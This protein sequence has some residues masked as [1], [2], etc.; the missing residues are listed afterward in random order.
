MDLRLLFQVSWL[1]KALC[2]AAALSFLC[3][4]MSL[5]A[6]TKPGDP[7]DGIMPMIDATR[8]PDLPSPDP[9][10]LVDYLRDA[11]DTR[12]TQAELM[13]ILSHINDADL[14][15]EVQPHHDAIA[16]FC[17]RPLMV[18]DLFKNLGAAAQH[19]LIDLTAAALSEEE[20]ANIGAQIH[21]R[22]VA[23]TPI[24]ADLATVTYLNALLDRIRPQISRTNLPWQV[25]VIDDPNQMNAISTAGGYIYF[26]TGL[27]N[28]ITNEA[29]LV[30][31][32]AHE[33]AHHELRH[34]RTIYQYLKALGLW[35]DDTLADSAELDIMTLLTLPMRSH[36]EQD[37]DTFAAEVLF[38]LGYT[39][40]ETI[41]LMA[42]ME[43][44]D[45]EV[46]IQGSFG[47]FLL[48]EAQHLLNSHPLSR[49]RACDLMREV[50][51]RQGWGNKVGT[52]N[53][54]SRTPMPF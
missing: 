27:L 41:A 26:Y 1:T 40:L 43:Q 29:Q 16:A 44:F 14:T 7:Q 38:R 49:L 18:G 2:A 8:Q 25:H 52:E 3:A 33:V 54:T 4:P 24:D 35:A 32:L 22:I 19:Q 21:A 5:F 9:A 6:D 39:P 28:Q 37:A 53:W 13:S 10:Q 30:G 46:E 31:V 11:Q 45:V 23:A 42:H 36:Q 48:R 17:R 12:L 15:P 51:L 20:E 34:T 50:E 47:T